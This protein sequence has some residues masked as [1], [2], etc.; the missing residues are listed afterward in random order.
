MFG[1][2]YICV[3][4]STKTLENDIF[5]E[6]KKS[7]IP[8]IWYILPGVANVQVR[9][10]NNWQRARTSVAMVTVPHVR[11]PHPL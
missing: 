1:P 7:Q 8:Q 9:S 6:N 11:E 10:I 5:L 4:Q 2:E 3:L